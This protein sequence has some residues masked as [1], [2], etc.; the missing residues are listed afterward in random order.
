M[1]LVILNPNSLKIDM[2]SH[3][4]RRMQSSLHRRRTRR[5]DV[6]SLPRMLQAMVWP[7]GEEREVRF[8]VQLCKLTVPYTCFI[9][10]LTLIAIWCWCAGK[11]Q[12]PPDFQQL[13]SAYWV[14]T[15]DMLCGPSVTEC[16]SFAWLPP[17]V[18]VYMLT[19]GWILKV[20]GA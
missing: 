16:N 12:R 5:T 11:W 14:Y 4:H 15:W 17:L 1:T 20:I 9:S 8:W 19:L 7:V 18:G 6:W 10:G 3:W 13:W 2:P